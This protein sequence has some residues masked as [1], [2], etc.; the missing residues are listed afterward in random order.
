[1]N[2]AFLDPLA[3]QT[4]QAQRAVVKKQEINQFGKRE[5]PIEPSGRPEKQPRVNSALP[6]APQVPQLRH[7]CVA[8][9]ET[10]LKTQLL[11]GSCSHRYCHECLEHL[12]KN[13]LLD[14]SLFPPK[15]CRRKLPIESAR[16][17]ISAE[18]WTRYE[19]KKIENKDRSRTY[20]CDPQCST[21]ILPTQPRAQNATCK[22]C[23]KKTC[24]VCKTMAHT[25]KC[26]Q[27]DQAILSMAKDNGWQRCPNCAH[28]VEL[29]SGCNHIT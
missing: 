22:K 29:R 8:C 23:T 28:L 4:P 2:S 15:C 7:E 27:T 1:V 21:Y 20:C 13:T 3:L 25:G 10:F 19:E 12:L 9:S 5:A 18:T 17:L 6:Q 16:A 26:P 14:E 11:T 24:T